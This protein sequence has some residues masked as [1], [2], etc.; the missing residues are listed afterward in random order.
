M[1]VAIKNTSCMIVHL[2]TRLFFVKL[3]AKKNA[4]C[5]TVPHQKLKSISK[6]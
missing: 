6:S 3:L 4:T 5:A 2:Y 1:V